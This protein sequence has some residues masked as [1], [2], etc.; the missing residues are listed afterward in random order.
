MRKDG[1]DRFGEALQ[2]VDTGDEDVLHAAVAQLRHHLQ[3]KLGALGLRQPQAQHLLLAGHLD[4]DGQV[5]RL[6]PHRTLAHLHVDAVQVDDWIH[7]IERPGLPGLDPIDHS[8]GDRG[9]QAGRD[10]RPVHLLQM[11]LDLAH[12]HAARIQRQNLVVE[13][14]PAGL[15]LGNQLRL[16]A[17]V[18][19]TRDRDRA[20][21]R[22]RP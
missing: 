2:A 15:M 8:I 16:E 1:F 13:A 9:N 21:R 12:R 5:H 18:P 20:A 10:L 22:S 19:I 14:D 6:D 3:P 17:A 7:R 4:A 11:R